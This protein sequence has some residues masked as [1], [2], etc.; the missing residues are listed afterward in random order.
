MKQKMGIDLDDTAFDLVGALILFHNATYETKLTRADFYSH[1]FE[2]VWG[3]THEE[4]IRKIDYFYETKYFSNMKPIPGAI[5]VIHSLAQENYLEAITARPIII[6]E[7]T[8]RQVR[9]YFENDFDKIFHSSNF[10]TNVQNDGTKLEICVREGISIMVEDVLEYA[11][12]F[13]NTGIR[14][15][16]FGNYPW[17]Q[18]GS[19]PPNIIRVKDWKGVLENS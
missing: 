13:A 1:K 18:N 7:K 6:K 14:V 19:L 8:E 10:F 12:Q 11:L 17:N 2:K 4:T 9:T 5:E 15:L 16:L 3:G